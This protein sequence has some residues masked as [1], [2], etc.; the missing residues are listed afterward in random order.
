M[1]GYSEHFVNFIKRVRNEY[2]DKIIIAGNVV[3]PEMV[4]ELIVNGADIIKIGIS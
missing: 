3:T 4:E 2:R 1:N